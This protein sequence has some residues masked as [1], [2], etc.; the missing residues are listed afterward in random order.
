MWLRPVDNALFVAE[1]SASSCDDLTKL[2]KAPILQSKAALLRL[3][4]MLRKRAAVNAARRDCDL[5]EIS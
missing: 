1:G 3:R 4:S 2:S 5:R